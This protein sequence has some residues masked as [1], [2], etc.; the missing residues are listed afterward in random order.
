M[1]VPDELIFSPGESRDSSNTYGQVR[2]MDDDGKIMAL[3]R[4]LD[5][6]LVDQIDELSKPPGGKSKVYSP[7]PL[8]IL[9]CIA[10]E[11][12]GQVMYFREEKKKEDAQREGFLRVAGSLHKTFSRALRK[13]VQDSVVKMWPE[14]DASKIKTI[15]HMLYYFQRN[16]L[17]HGYQSKG[18]L[19]LIP[20]VTV[21]GKVFFSCG[22]WK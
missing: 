14:K 9:T 15:A 8:A 17:V 3:K 21:T 16:T 5:R 1:A 6:F 7:F 10:I 18:V 4:R 13:N 2:A 19:V 11:T 22:L 20:K 12:L